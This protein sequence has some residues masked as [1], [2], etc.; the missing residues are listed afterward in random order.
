MLEIKLN[1][2]FHIRCGNWESKDLTKQ[3]ILY[4]AKDAIVSLEIFYALV[5]LRRANRHSLFDLT[6]SF[7]I[8]KELITYWVK[9]HSL[10]DEHDFSVFTYSHSSDILNELDFSLPS[11]FT[12]TKPATWLV[13][14]AYSLCQGITDTSYKYKLPS[15]VKQNIANV[16]SRALSTKASTKPYKHQCREKPLYENCFLLGPDKTVLATVNRSKAQWYITKGLGEYVFLAVIGIHLTSSQPA[17]T[18]YK[19]T[20]ETLTRYRFGVFN[21]NFEHIFSHFVLLFLLSTFK[22]QLPAGLMQNVQKRSNI[23]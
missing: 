16:Q 13:E 3:Q 18:C 10:S 5:L 20:I 17:F 6:D 4:A 2:N 1:K 22:M 9:L 12:L 7:E 19:L 11:E 21:V 15:Y 8:N 14:L 23:L